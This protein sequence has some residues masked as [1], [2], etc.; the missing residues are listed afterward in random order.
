MLGRATALA[1]SGASSRASAHLGILY[2]LRE[3][4]IEP[5]V[6]TG[7]SSGTCMAAVMGTGEP[8]DVLTER[9]VEMTEKMGGTAGL[10]T[11]PFTSV[12]SGRYV[13]RAVMN[14]FG[15]HQLEDLVVPARVSACDLVKRERVIFDRGP[16]WKI[17]RTTGSLPAILPPVVEDGRV[18]VDGGIMDTILLAPLARD[19]ARGLVYA[20]TLVGTAI[21]PL[22]DLEPYG[23]WLSGWKILWDRIT[24]FGRPGRKYPDIGTIVI[25]ALVLE[26]NRRLQTL[27]DRADPERLRLFESP[28]SP[29]WAS[30]RQRGATS[31]A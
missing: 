2:A 15:D 7:T 27:A 13:C 8:N 21:Q 14:M 22:A 12:V 5:D 11:L 1:L 31:P 29:T 3:F 20:S 6:Y 10:P 23:P 17:F 26:S 9:I 30:S 24:A 19:C 4:G 16:I 25:E 18:L 28:P